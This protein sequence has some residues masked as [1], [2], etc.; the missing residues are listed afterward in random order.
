M[1][2]GAALNMFAGAALFIG[3]ALCLVLSERVDVSLAWNAQV[4]GK[5]VGESGSL[6]LANFTRHQVFGRIAVSF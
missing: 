5:A 1:Y 4:S 2:E 3:P 6:N